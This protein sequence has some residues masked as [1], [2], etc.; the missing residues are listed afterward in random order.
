MLRALQATVALL[1]L[2]N[3]A[4]A[5]AAPAAPV[6]AATPPP[7]P[8]APDSADRHRVFVDLTVNGETEGQILVIFTDAGVFASRADLT[9]YGVPVGKA[10]CITISQTCYIALDELKPDITYSF[11]QSA[12]AL[13]ITMSASAL[14]RKSVSLGLVQPELSD[15]HVRGNVINYSI[16]VV[17]KAPVAGVLDDRFGI[18]KNVVIEGGVGK[19]TGGVVQR[20]YTDLTLDYPDV[21]KRFIVGDSVAVGGDLGGSFNFGGFTIQRQFSLDPYTINYP[22]PT[23]QTAITQPSQAQIFVNGVMVKTVDLPPGYYTLSNIP[24][25]AGISNAQVVIKN[26]YGQ[27]TFNTGTYGGVSLLRKGLT[28]Y[29]YGLGFLQENQGLPNQGYGPVVGSAHYRL[30]M[31]DQATIGSLIQWSAGLENAGIDYDA[32]IG[33]GVFHAGAATSIGTGRAGSS[34]TLAFTATAPRTSIAVAV[35]GQTRN[36]TLLS[37]FETASQQIDSALVSWSRQLSRIASIALSAQVTNYLNMGA[38]RQETISFTQLV[39]SWTLSSSLSFANAPSVPGQPGGST[40]SLAITLVRQVGSRE[41]VSQTESVNVQT[42]QG[43]ASGVQFTSSALT[44]LD[45]SY[46]AVVQSK[47]GG[48][49]EAGGWAN[50]ATPYAA[51][52]LFASPGSQLSS[53]TGSL[54]GAVVSTSKGTFFTQSVPDA[55]ALVVTGTP[56]ADVFL[57]GQYV[58]RTG[59]NGAMIVPFLESNYSNSIT[60]SSEGLPLSQILQGPPSAQ[61]GPSYHNGALVKNH[62][63]QVHALLGKV[64][65][66]EGANDIVPMYGDAKLVFGPFNY[67]SP[68]DEDGRVYFQGVLPGTYDLTISVPGKNCKTSVTVPDFNDITHDLGTIHCK[69]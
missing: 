42:G 20:T 18:A 11:D 9:Q 14:Q 65:F 12:L 2:S 57:S 59:G 4:L 10:I 44:P 23:L 47:Q 67:S 30:G 40:H 29:Q 21:Q 63:E 68:I 49:I 1:L 58:G 33:A 7:A 51:L 15:E 19:T 41:D 48:G 5:A 38:V 55:Y 31:S 56:N 54:N 36:Y 52:Q 60:V 53:V 62:V 37:S 3:Q 61:I 8:A 26:A 17:Q 50:L 35:Q 27:T 6:Y 22:T 46:N 39:G 16:N 24:V 13:S 45:S 34:G 69:I 32:Q 66:K 25:V 64:L 28:D 43:A